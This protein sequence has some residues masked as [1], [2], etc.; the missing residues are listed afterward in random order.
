MKHKLES[1]ILTP[2]VTEACILT[3]IPY[4]EKFHLSEYQMMAEKLCAKGP[5]KVVISGIVQGEFIANYCYEKGSKPH[6]IR[7]HKVGTQRSGTGA[8]STCTVPLPILVIIRS[9][10][11][12]RSTTTN[13]VLSV[14]SPKSVPETPWNSGIWSSG[15]W[16]RSWKI[17][18]RIPMN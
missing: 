18:T 14:S 7:S 11:T 1:S 12:I 9:S 6:I 16:P 4:K 8:P 3:D 17:P 5:Q 15:P 10:T 2:N 13:T